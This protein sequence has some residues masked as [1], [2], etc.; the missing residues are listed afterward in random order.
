[1]YICLVFN[2]DKVS[3][4][5][6]VEDDLKKVY[7]D[8]VLYGFTHVMTS[9]SIKDFTSVMLHVYV[10]WILVELALTRFQTYMRN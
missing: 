8:A 5:E 6:C 9:T 7:L 4:S 2:K 3:D 1:M 10:E